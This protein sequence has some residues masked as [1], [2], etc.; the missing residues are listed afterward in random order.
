M[1]VDETRIGQAKTLQYFTERAAMRYQQVRSVFV[2]AY[3]RFRL[4]RWEDVTQHW[5]SLPDQSSFSF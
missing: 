3:R 1:V 2:T 4:G 5:R